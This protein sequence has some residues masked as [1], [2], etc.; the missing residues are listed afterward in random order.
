MKINYTWSTIYG[1][2]NDYIYDETKIEFGENGVFLIDPL[3]TSLP[4]IINNE[5]IDCTFLT[6]FVFTTTDISSGNYIK[7]QL[8]NDNYNWYFYDSITN[9][10][11]DSSLTTDLSGSNIPSEYTPNALEEFSYQI[12][13]GKIY[14]KVFFVSDGT[15]STPSMLEQI[16]LQGDKYY[17]DI[18]TVRGILEPYGLRF[19][20]PLTGEY[21]QAEDFLSNS[22]LKSMIPLADSYINNR[23]YTD[24]YYH[25][26][27]VEYH[28]G[29]GKDSL[30]T[31]DFPIRKITQVIM[32]NPLLQA[33]RTFTDFELI[34][35]AEWGELFL[36]PIYPAFMS[37][38]PARSMF[39][40]IFI[41]GRR[42]IEV[43]YDWGYEETPEDIKFAAS[44]YAAIQVLN[45]FWAYL[46]RGV[47]SRSF[48]GYSE[49]F[50]QKP[51][52]GIIE[53]WEKEIQDVISSKR[54]VFP[55]SI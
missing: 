27:V 2:Q 48:D 12:G 47:Q 43:D 22:R 49:S 35:H 41:V 26:N 4:Y 42:N 1:N 20:N 44:K 5:G 30:R 25:R 15:M 52:A 54:K 18:Q 53:S 23:T 40:N 6:K 3:D 51:F 24:F 11:S 32:Y 34:I 55:R 10:W 46:S 9:T 45:S 28:D 50:G 17:T 39:G 14:W 8:S 31:Y 21:V 13:A 36:P 16:N 19:Q 29:N 7:A 33:M 38:A 37:D